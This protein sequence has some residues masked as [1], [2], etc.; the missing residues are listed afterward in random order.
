ME[1]VATDMSHPPPESGL[2]RVKA[3]HTAT[4]KNEMTVDTQ[5]AALSSMARMLYLVLLL[6]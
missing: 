1:R 6:L 2:L 5:Y 3:K 4:T